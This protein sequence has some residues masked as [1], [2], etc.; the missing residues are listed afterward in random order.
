MRRIIINEFISLDG[1]IQSPGGPD[2]DTTGGFNVGGWVAKK[3]DDI[4]DQVLGDIMEQSYDLLL[5]RFTYQIWEPYW[6]NQTG[7]IAEKFNQVNKYVASRTLKEASWKNTVLLNGDTIQQVKA[8]KA[9]DGIDLHMWGSSD[10]IHSLLRERLIDQMNIFIH[11]V[12][13]GKGKKLFQDGAIPGN[14]KLIKH[15]VSTTGVIL[16]TYETDRELQIGNAG[17]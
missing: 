14:Y 3:S 15:T 7:P 4:T 9:S 16:A 8:L 11:P 12:I 10:F 17:E 2:E 5:G 13:L 6:P 1:V